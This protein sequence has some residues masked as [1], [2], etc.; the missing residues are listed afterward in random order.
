MIVADMKTLTLNNVTYDIVDANAVH[1]DG[2]AEVG[3]TIVVKSVDENG[4]PIEWEVAD[5]VGGGGEAPDEYVVILNKTLD[6]D[7]A[8]DAEWG[9]ESHQYTYRHFWTTDINGNSIDADG[10]YFRIFVPSQT[11]VTSGELQLRVGQNKPT[12]WMTWRHHDC[13]G[14][15]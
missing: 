6:A 7:V 9:G 4:K 14:S 1:F 8:N 11:S 10:I 15:Y 12:G 3:Q 5:S 13:K 2:A